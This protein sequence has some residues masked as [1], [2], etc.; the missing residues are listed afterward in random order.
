MFYIVD[1]IEEDI[2]VLQDENGYIINLNKNS[3]DEKVKEGDC[4]RKENNRFCLDMEETKKRKIKIN[5]LMKGMW[6]D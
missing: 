4:L 6:E 1:R 5:K 2:I 3:I